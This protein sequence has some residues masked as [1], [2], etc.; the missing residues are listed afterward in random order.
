TNSR[1][2]PPASA[3]C[4]R[5]AAESCGCANTLTFRDGEIEAEN[6]DLLAV[7]RRLEELRRDG[8]WN[9]ADLAVYGTGGAARAALAAAES[10]G[11][12][13]T[14]LGRDATRAAELAQRFSARVGTTPPSRP[15][16]VL[17]HA[18]PVGR[19]GSGTLHPSIG[20]WLGPH[21]HVLDFV[22][23]AEE[24]TLAELARHHG[25]TYEDG[26]R[27]LGY[28]AAASYEIWWGRSLSPTLIDAALREAA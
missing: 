15:P 19:R 11:A 1:P 24:P 21:T 4:N 23:R 28:A 22:Y 25:A 20:P 8:R 14:I 18:T 6:T 5:P 2:S 16:S 13:A 7:L 12:E 27:L 9:G 17:I 10:L 3:T 26:T